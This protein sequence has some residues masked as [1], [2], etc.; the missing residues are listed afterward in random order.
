MG[1]GLEMNKVKFPTIKLKARNPRHESN[2]NTSEPIENFQINGRIDNKN[3]KNKKQIEKQV[4]MD[5]EGKNIPLLSSNAS[6]S[7]TGVS[8]YLRCQVQ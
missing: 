3:N 7:T 8:H 2:L 4:F 5:G 1:I 6:L